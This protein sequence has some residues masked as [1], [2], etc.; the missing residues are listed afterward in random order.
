[1]SLVM[2]ITWP[3]LPPKKGSVSFSCSLKIELWGVG[4]TSKLSGKNTRVA[5]EGDQ[6][7]DEINMSRNARN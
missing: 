1:M 5:L 7:G 3:F 2:I 4:K 6:W